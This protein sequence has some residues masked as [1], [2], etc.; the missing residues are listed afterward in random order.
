MFTALLPP[1]DSARQGV[2][3]TANTADST[4]IF[5]F[6][7]ERHIELDSKDHGPLA[8]RLVESLCGTDDAAATDRTIS[9]TGPPDDYLD[10]FSA[11]PD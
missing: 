9:I 8:L 2:D 7:L 6:Y 1:V 11:V 4:S 3:V 5:R 10:F